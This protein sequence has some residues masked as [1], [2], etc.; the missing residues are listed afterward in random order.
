MGNDLS[1][2]GVRGTT[3]RV[4]GTS[5]YQKQCCRC[6]DFDKESN[7][8]THFLSDLLEWD[9]DAA[10]KVTVPLVHQ[11]TAKKYHFDTL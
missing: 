4:N 7:A 6:R 8:S 1:S 2:P 5:E 3:P 10:A 9:D 11:H